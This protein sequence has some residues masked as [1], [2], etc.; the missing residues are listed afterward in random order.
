MSPVWGARAENCPFPQRPIMSLM[1]VLGVFFTGK[2]AL[3]ALLHR[4]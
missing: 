3:L 2:T 1:F 4:R